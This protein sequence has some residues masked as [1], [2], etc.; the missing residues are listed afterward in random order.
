MDYDNAISLH[1]LVTGNAK[2]RRSERLASPSASD[3]RISFGCINVPAT[4]YDTHVR[5][6][7]AARNGVVYVLPETRPLSAVFGAGVGTPGR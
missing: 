2:D 1:P 6:L 3:N 7:F 4:F 5:P